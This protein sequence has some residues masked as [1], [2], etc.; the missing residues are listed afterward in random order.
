MMG[1]YYE[2]DGITI[3]HGDCR[4]IL[5]SLALTDVATAIADPPYAETTLAWDRWPEGWISAL[6]VTVR[7]L[8]CFGSMRM[9]LAR[10][11][12]FAG[13]S[14]AQEVVWEKHNGS[15][16]ANDRFK[17]VHEFATH[18]YRGRWGAL[19]ITPQL[20]NEATKRTIRHKRKPPQH[21]GAIASVPYRSEDGGPKLQRSVI[22]ARSCH[23]HALHPTQKPLD[24]VLPLVRYS[25]M[26]GDVVLDPMM[27]SGTTLEAARLLGRR[28]I[29]IEVSERY[30]EI[31]A[32]RLSQ[33]VL[34][35]AAAPTGG[36]T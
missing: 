5:P 1:P 6:P 18:W 15:G 17:R 26:P 4:E 22:Y 11:A 16:F 19:T 27:G 32:K 29:G 23:G 2:A 30:C 9:L 35:F 21:T 8:W 7:Q 10:Q 13:W 24:I 20:V 36:E 31:G 3:Y 12:D 14:Y 28:A 25:T 33:Q 34:D